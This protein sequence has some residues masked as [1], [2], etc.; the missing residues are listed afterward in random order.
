[1]RSRCCGEL[2]SALDALRR[3]AVLP[4]EGTVEVGII[5]KAAALKDRSRRSSL[6]KEL[7][8]DLKAFEQDVAIYADADGV[9]EEMGEII[10]AHIELLGKTVQRQRLLIVRTDIFQNAQDQWVDLRAG[11]GPFPVQDQPVELH[12]DLKEQP[13]TENAAAVFRAGKFLRKDGEFAP[14]VGVC[15]VEAAVCGAEAVGEIGR[16][17]GKGGKECFVDP[18]DDALVRRS[19]F[20]QRAVEFHRVD[21]QDI[22]GDEAVGASLHKVIHLAAEEKVDLKKVMVV[23]GDLLDLGVLIME[24]LESRAGHILTGIKGLYVLLHEGISFQS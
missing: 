20:D 18:E 13:L 11:T 24:D 3:F 1:M 6:G 19:G 12:D 2:R 17:V 7:A 22:P 4:F 9:A 5:L 23:D 21:E 10:F 16:I 15:G 8:R 14:N